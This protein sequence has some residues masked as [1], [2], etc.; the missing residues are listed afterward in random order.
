[1]C[2]A[3][4]IPDITRETL[5]FFGNLPPGAEFVMQAKKEMP[6]DNY[7]TIIS[8]KRQGRKEGKNGGFQAR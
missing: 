7:A 5:L 8:K 4:R 3:I 2:T 6:S 1:L